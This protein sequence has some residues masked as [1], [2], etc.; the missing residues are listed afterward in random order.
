MRSTKQYCYYKYIYTNKQISEV[1]KLAQINVKA[2][3]KMKNHWI[4]LY[5]KVKATKSNWHNNYYKEKS[6]SADQKQEYSLWNKNFRLNAK[7]GNAMLQPCLS[8][9]QQITFLTVTLSVKSKTPSHPC[10]LLS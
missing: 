6:L 3:C 1:S 7:T 8:N 5:I 9:C 10:S 4:R 2:M